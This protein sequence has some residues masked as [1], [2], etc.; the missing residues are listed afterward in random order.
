MHDHTPILHF[1]VLSYR[2]G[3]KKD[4]LNSLIIVISISSIFILQFLSSFHKTMAISP[5]FDL[6]ELINK[7]HH[8]AQIYGNS[9]AHLK[10]NYTDILAVNYIS[11]G[12][13]LNATFWLASG[14]KNSSLST[15]NQPGRKIVYGMLIDVD[16]NTKTGYNGADYD[17]YVE[18]AA[19]KLSAY[20][21][22]LSSTGVY[23]LVGSKINY[24]QPFV[25]PN[26]GLGSVNLQLDLSS[27][28]NPRKYNLLFYS[29]ESFKSNEVREFTNWV[30]IPPPRLLITTLP[31]NILIRQGEE[32]LILAR[33]KST[34]GFSNDVVNVTVGDTE[35]GFNSSQLHVGI[36]RIQPPLFRIGIPQQTS[37]GTYAIPLF[38][39]IREPSVENQITKPV[40]TNPRG[41]FVDPEFEISKKYPTVGYFT[42]PVNL[43]ITVIPPSTISDQFRE[44]WGAYGQFIGVTVGGF[45]G[46]AAT[47]MFNRRK[48]KN[49]NF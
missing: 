32:Q 22:Q 3:P 37:L 23:R 44:F 40:Y 45:V 1:F 31:S 49:Q 5:S 46:A 20:L 33:I 42:Q 26:V 28:D 21:Y 16:S 48:K 7:N 43:T 15:Y 12:K 8:W 11:N 13:S 24:S 4:V 34:S 17:Y 38:V 14:F 10:S 36:Q 30:D 6:Q 2:P 18:S 47:L 25:D 35:S 19:G 39:T 29:A 9:D 41:G 27:I